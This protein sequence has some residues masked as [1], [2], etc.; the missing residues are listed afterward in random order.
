MKKALAMLLTLAMLFSC[1]VVGVAE[2]A[3]AVPPQKLEDCT[4]GWNLGWEDTWEDGTVYTSV[5]KGD[6]H[7]NYINGVLESYGYRIEVEDG[8]VSAEFAADHRQTG[9]SYHD[10][11][12]YKTYSSYNGGKSWMTWDEETWNDVKVE[13]PEGVVI[14]ETPALGEY[15]YIKPVVADKLEDVDLENGK[16]NEYDWGTSYDGDNIYANYDENGN[17]EYYSY[18]NEDHTVQ[19]QCNWNHKITG[20]TYADGWDYYNSYD[21]ETWYLWIWDEETGD[22]I[23]TEVELPDYAEFEK[24]PALGEYVYNVAA[25]ADQLDVENVTDGRLSSWTDENGDIGGYGYDMG[26]VWASY[27]ADG[28]LISYN[29][30]N[31][32]GDQSVTYDWNHK[33][34]QIGVK[35]EDGNWLY[36]DD[37]GETWGYWEW[38]EEIEDSVWVEDEL[39]E[40]TEIKDMPALGTPVEFDRVPVQNLED[41][42]TRLGW[43]WEEE[44]EDGNVTTEFYSDELAMHMSFDAQGKLISYEHWTED[45]NDYVVY[46]ADNK[47][48]YAEHWTEDGVL[49]RYDGEN[50]V[51][52]KS[53]YNEE[54]ED[55]EETELDKAPEDLEVLPPLT[56]KVDDVWYPNNTMGVLGLPLR[57]TV[58]GLTSKWYHVVP[59]NVSVD[60]TTTIPLVASNLY[61]ISN[62][63]VT[64]NGDS[65]TVTY[66]GLSPHGY[67]W[68]DDECVAWF[69]SLDQIT[70]EWL[71]NPES[72]LAFGQEISRANDL[73]NAEIALLFI[74]NHVTYRQPYFSNNT[75]LPRYWPNLA[76]WKAY[77][78]DLTAM[79]NTLVPAETAEIVDSPVADDVV[80]SPSAGDIVDSP[81][82][83]D[84]VDS[85]DAGAVAE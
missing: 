78:A 83:G 67:G 50:D 42:E 39:P 40:G 8:M 76:Q 55:F 59:V 64:V 6:V 5:S 75:F 63:Y 34:T 21:G 57:D 85:P 77:R 58:P 65:V 36:S 31:E 66:D 16:V 29:F 62:A 79:L 81:S 74:C 45:W 15:V 18:W 44:D 84:I 51:W 37:G 1:L 32:A 24:L 49:Y 13:L 69:T 14:P 54:T 22:S 38:D 80:D 30:D 9:V 10:F 27:D 20:Y 68:I 53:E 46:S 26:D 71:N 35:T 41:L 4:D 60:G 47:L 3:I 19:V 72:D 12:N 43:T 56:N 82:A 52:T 48:L 25:P 61:F 7:A 28:K 17:L 70:T 11:V 23:R 2:E 73:D 33:L